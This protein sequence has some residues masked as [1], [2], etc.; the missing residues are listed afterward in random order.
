MTELVSIVEAA[1][2]LSISPWTIR[3]HLKGGTI[4]PV[5][6]G[7]RVLIPR[8]EVDRIAREGLPSLKGS[9]DR[10]GRA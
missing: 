9:Q 1:K 10:P 6:C 8:N 4:T 5:R 7:R 2:E 3:A